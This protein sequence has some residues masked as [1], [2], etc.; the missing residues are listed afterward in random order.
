MLVLLAKAAAIT[1]FSAV[2]LFAMATS[3][4]PVAPS[5]TAVSAVQAGNPIWDSAPADNPIWD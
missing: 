3:A 4:A 5:D 2:S 1:T